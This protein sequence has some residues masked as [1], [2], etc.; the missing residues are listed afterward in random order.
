MLDAIDEEIVRLLRANARLS[1][2][3]IGREVHLSRPAVHERVRRLEEQGII[4]RYAAQVDWAALGLPLLAFVWLR[5]AGPYSADLPGALLGLSGKEAHVEEA[6][7]VTGE[8][9]ILLKARAASPLALQ[10]LLDRMHGI[11]GLSNTM[12]ALVLS[13]IEEA[14]P[15]GQVAVRNGSAA[16][17]GN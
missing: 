5:I 3:Q 1:Q 15:T 2:E 11:P 13:S 4:R 9:C 10:D 14:G 16:R 17:G 12:T 8:W 7:R 6:H